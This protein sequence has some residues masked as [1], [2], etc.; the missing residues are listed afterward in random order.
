MAYPER[1]PIY[2]AYKVIIDQIIAEKTYKSYA[3]SE[4]SALDQ[5]L[6]AAFREIR[7]AHLMN[8]DWPAEQ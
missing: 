5:S 1:K 2:D 8:K 4:I 6:L 3:E 7:I